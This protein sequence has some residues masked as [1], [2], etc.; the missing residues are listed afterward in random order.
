MR[1]LASL[2]LAGLAL[3]GCGLSAYLTYRELF[4]IEAICT[5]CVASAILMTALAAIAVVRLLVAD[6]TPRPAARPDA[7]RPSLG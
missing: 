7:D 6:G 4:T 1:A 5:W 3:A 2:L